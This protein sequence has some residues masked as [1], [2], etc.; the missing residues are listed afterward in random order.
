MYISIMLIYAS[1]ITMLSIL[2]AM[3]FFLTSDGCFKVIYISFNDFTL[4]IVL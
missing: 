3:T 2:E 1:S 4:K